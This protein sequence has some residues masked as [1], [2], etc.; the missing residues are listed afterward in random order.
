MSFCYHNI[1]ISRC[2][3]YTPGDNWLYNETPRTNMRSFFF[4]SFKKFI[5]LLYLLRTSPSTT[6]NNFDPLLRFLIRGLVWFDFETEGVC[7][8]QGLGLRPPGLGRRDLGGQW[9]LRSVKGRRPRSS[10]RVYHFTTTS[11]V[12]GSRGLGPR[13]GWAFG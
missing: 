8:V 5:H 2:P 4:F 9:S 6:I 11:R 10:S 12:R 1:N 13:G 7:P 3:V